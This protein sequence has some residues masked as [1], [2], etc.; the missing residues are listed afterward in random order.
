MKKILHFPAALLVVC[1]LTG[2]TAFKVNIL[3][4]EKK[5]LKEVTLE[6]SGADR[7]LVIAI[8]GA[9]TL[10]GRKGLVGTREG[11]LAKVAARLSKARRDHRVKAVV[12][13]IDSPGGSVTASDALYH[14]IERFKKETGARIVAAM[15]GIAT[16]G[17][18][19][20]A[21]PADWII[22]H[23]TTVTGSV[24]VIFLQPKAV[25]LMKKIG[26]SVNV[27]KSGRD[28]D[29][30]SPFRRDTAEEQ[31]IFQDL[32]QTLADRF[33]ELVARHRGLDP[34][35]LEKVATARIYLGPEARRLG[36]VDAIGYLP[37]AISKARQLAGLADGSRVIA[38]R[39]QEAPD[40]SIYNGAEARR[41][42]GPA[43]ALADLA[44]LLPN[45]RPGFYYL[46][47]PQWVG[48][49]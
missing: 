36:L 48:G 28:K 43:G 24:G 9:I 20:V 5:A 21:L 8:S 37:D 15:M 23:P 16:S 49:S 4:G 46:W 7:V 44:A 14:E 42:G 19:Y 18:Y 17:G 47:L 38:Y 41:T 1:M 13:K 10:S 11:T 40:A 3:T 27:R 25:G 26:L 22:A 30:G 32:T 29:M 35:T 12:F 45:P 31:R 34:E 6:G 2:C 33:L 39:R